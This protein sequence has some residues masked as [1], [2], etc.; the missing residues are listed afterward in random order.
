MKP[1]RILQVV[2]RMDRGGIETMLMNLYRSID[3]EKVQFDFLAHYGKPDAD[4]NDEIR[5]LGGIVYEM[6]QIKTPSR[7]YYHK[8]FEYRRALTSFFSEHREYDVVHGHMTNTAAI[9]MP[10]AKKCG[11][12]GCLIAHSHQEKSMQGLTGRLSRLL[13][14]RIPSLATDWFACSNVAA[15]WFYK[16]SDIDS[17]K[18]TIIKNGIDTKSFEYSA[19][20]RSEVRKELGLGD[21]LVIGH[22]GG[23]HYPKNQVFL[24]D[25]LRCALAIRPDITLCF[26]G[27]G[28]DRAAAEEYARQAGVDSHIRFLGLRTDV[29]RLMQAF[30]AFALPSFFE[31]LPLVSVEAQTAGLP[32]LFSSAVTAEANITGLAEFLPL[33]RGA[34]AWAEKLIGMAPAAHRRSMAREI[35]SAGY[36]I[37]TSAAFLQDFYLSHR[38]KY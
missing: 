28:V 5:E 18:V 36:D 15:R 6:P 16:Q 37:S 14:Y 17:G 24:I 19:Q 12:V 26:A 22:V 23:F 32:C 7:T 29:C 35:V 13:S 8:L 20:I 1:M 25:V 34:G 33:E 4:Y 38:T 11:G 9:Y 27:D 21:G 2:G 10:I 3:R 30:D 31:G